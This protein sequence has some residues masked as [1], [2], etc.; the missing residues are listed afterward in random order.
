MANYRNCEEIRKAIEK[1]ISEKT[2]QARKEVNTMKTG[3]IITFY[4][5]G[6]KPNGVWSN[7]KDILITAE[8]TRVY[9]NGAVSCTDP[10]HTKSFDYISV[11]EIISTTEI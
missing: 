4:S 9:K 11:N 5:N 7:K 8:V 10:Q 3:N 6:Y 1:S 2:A